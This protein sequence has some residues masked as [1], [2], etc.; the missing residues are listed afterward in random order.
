[1]LGDGEGGEDGLV[2]GAVGAVGLLVVETVF[3]GAFGWSFEAGEELEKGGLSGT[4]F[5]GDDEAISGFE[6][7]VE[8][9]E[10]PARTEP[11]AYSLCR[12]DHVFIMDGVHS[13][14]RPKCAGVAEW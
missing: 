8:A 5:A 7:D 3:E 6:V 2:E 12:E 4:V 14:S 1:M 13:L 10:K 11:L 9:S